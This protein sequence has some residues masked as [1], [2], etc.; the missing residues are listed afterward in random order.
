MFIQPLPDHLAKHFRTKADTHPH[1]I[2]KAMNTENT[3]AE[4][5][6]DMRESIIPPTSLLTFQIRALWMKSAGTLYDRVS[7]WVRVITFDCPHPLS[8]ALNTGL[9]DTATNTL[10][11]STKMVALAAKTS[12]SCKIVTTRWM[13]LDSSSQF[14][15]LGHFQNH[16]H[17][18]YHH[19]WD[20][21]V[22]SSFIWVSYEKPSPLYCVT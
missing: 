13:R 14:W 9:H 1:L 22:R 12:G 21:V 20:L 16:H 2:H 11:N 8:S 3:K 4:D 19:H 15:A 6:P 7:E 17:H 5:E 18:H 10:A